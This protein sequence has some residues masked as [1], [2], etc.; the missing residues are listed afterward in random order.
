[1]KRILVIVGLVVAFT[2]FTSGAFAQYKKGDNLLNVG[3]GLN[4]YFSG[5]NPFGVSYEKG[6]T[7][8]ISV[9][10]AFDYMSYHY[11]YVGVSES[12]SAFYL[13]A[14]GSYHFNKLLNINDKQWDIY[15]GLSLGYRSVTW[16]D[17]NFKYNNGYY[18]SG[19]GLGVHFGGKYYF[20]D[21]VGAFLELGAMGITYSR[22]G[23]AFKF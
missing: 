22:L 3:I 16:S 11:G 9:G 18:G 20:S 21:K 7:S 19:L 10:G 14:R 17:N 2:T 15:A 23:V 13:G 12:F 1:M 4:S 5:G 8:D 6:V